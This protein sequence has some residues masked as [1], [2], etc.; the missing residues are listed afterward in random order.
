MKRITLSAIAGVALIAA[1]CGSGNDGSASSP[2]GGG[3]GS[4][5]AAKTSTPTAATASIT[6]KQT[7]LGT[8]LAFG[9]EKRTVYLWEGDKG[10]TSNCSGACAKAWPPV[11]GKPAAVGGAV[12]A[13]LG[14]T[15]RSDG[16]SQVTYKG[17]PIYTFVKDKDSEDAYGQESDAFGAEWYALKAS[18][19]KAGD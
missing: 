6:T 5:P 12:T 18:G 4:A 10:S 14:T 15:M 11:T 7:K 8:V 16:I 9:P 17:H 13:D 1:G 19:E 2:A 3:Y